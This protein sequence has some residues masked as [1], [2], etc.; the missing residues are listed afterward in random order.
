VLEAA[1]IAA[2][3]EVGQLFLTHI[4]PK[5]GSNRELIQEART[6]FPSVDVAEDF[7]E[8]TMPVPE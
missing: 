4:S 8:I 3:A 5:H 2:R 6:V 1:T 7:R